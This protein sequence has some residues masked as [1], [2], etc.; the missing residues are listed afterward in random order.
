MDTSKLVPSAIAL[1]ICYGVAHFVKN[2]MVKAAA[3]GAM[4]VIVAKQVPYVREALV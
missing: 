2:P 4:G 3:F 1:G